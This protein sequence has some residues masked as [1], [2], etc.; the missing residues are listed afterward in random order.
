MR[1]VFVIS[2]ALLGV[3]F[4]V[5]CDQQSFSQTQPTPVPVVQQT[6]ESTTNQISSQDEIIKVYKNDKNGYEIQYPSFFAVDD[7]KPN[8]VELSNITCSLNTKLCMLGIDYIQIDVVDN[9]GTTF[10]QNL[11]EYSNDKTC[12]KIKIFPL[13]ENFNENELVDAI[14]CEFDEVPKQAKGGYNYIILNGNNVYRITFYQGDST[15]VAFVNGSLLNIAKDTYDPLGDV[16]MR[17]FKF[18]K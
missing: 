12:K 2:S 18:I 16:M 3:V 11:K 15:L 5:G 1:K 4:L 17:T 8:H 7:T 13:P 9:D 14:R 6:N 10:S